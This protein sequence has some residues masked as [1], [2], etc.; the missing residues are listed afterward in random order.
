M[1]AGG[2]SG[3]GLASVELLVS[4][5]ALV[6]SGDIQPPPTTG[7]FLFVKTDVRNWKD[8]T[9]LF[10]A[11]KDKYGKVDYVFANAGIGPRANYLA[12]EVD[13]N[14]D[15]KEPNK[16]TLDINLN[17]VVNTATLAVHYIKDQAEGGSIVL[18]G[19]STG[20]HPVR[21]VDYCEST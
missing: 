9:N 2:S 3:I 6:V 19:S 8:L 17:S 13:E 20:L 14:G 18:M 16:D 4:L 7:D 10:K 21:A 15:L 1:L 11:A 5:G 12:L